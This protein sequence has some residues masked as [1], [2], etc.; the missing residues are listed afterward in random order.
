MQP[1]TVAELP[2]GREWL[3]EIKWDGWRVI[4][5]KAGTSVRLWSRNQKDLTHAFP[6]IAAAVAT[7]EAESAVLDGELVAVNED[8]RPSFSALQ[9]RGSDPSRLFLYAFDL[10]HVDGEDLRAVPLDRRKARLAKVLDSSA[11]R[12]SPAMPGDP[13]DMAAEFRR[14]GLEGIVAKKRTSSYVSG[15]NSAWVKFRLSLMQEFVVGAYVPP[16]NSVEALV[17]GYY[18]GKRLI[19]CGRVRAGFNQLNRRQLAPLLNRLS[20]DRC[21]FANL[22]MKSK[23]RFGA[24]I[25]EDDM[26]RMQWVRPSLVV[27]VAFVEWTP[28]GVLRHPKYLGIRED[29]PAANVRRD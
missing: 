18:E 10:L 4:A 20:S 21:P 24:G 29:K 12:I 8:G 23:G 9:R 17:L 25:T 7:I 15:E 26:A 11:V 28:H 6:S 14:L 13:R 2:E 5:I 22:P 1:L 27:Q 3:Y 19:C 16:V